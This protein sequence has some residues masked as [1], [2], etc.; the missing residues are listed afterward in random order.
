MSA[1]LIEG[2]AVWISPDLLMTQYK[3]TAGR[4]IYGFSAGDRSWVYHEVVEEWITAQEAGLETIGRSFQNPAKL[5]KLFQGDCGVVTLTTASANSPDKGPVL[6]LAPSRQ[7]LETIETEWI[8]V[9]GKGY[10]YLGGYV[11]FTLD[12]GLQ[13]ILEITYLLSYMTKDDSLPGKLELDG[14][15]VIVGSGSC[16]PLNYTRTNWRTRK[17]EAIPLSNELKKILKQYVR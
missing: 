8:L 1:L 17:E 6:K 15:C 7:L 14:E 11:L 2:D 16:L 9:N 13:Q 3:S 4:D 5:L 12:P 10:E